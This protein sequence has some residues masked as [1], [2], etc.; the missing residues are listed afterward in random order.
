MF[1]HEETIYKVRG[2]NEREILLAKAFI[3]GAVYCWLKNRENE[4][5]SLRDLFGGTN[6]V[7]TGTPLEDLWWK[8]SNEGKSDEEA[9][10]QAAQDAGW[11]LK[12]V[13]AEDT[14]RIF[15]K[16][17]NG[18]VNSYSWVRNNTD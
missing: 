12:A 17:K 15:D 4:P 13:L 16:K 3:K 10:D 7:W 6:A 9:F 5:F 11:L 8:H 1:L 18:Q 2:L 14:K